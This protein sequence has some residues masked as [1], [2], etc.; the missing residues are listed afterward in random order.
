[1]IALRRT[2]AEDADWIE[3]LVGDEETEPFLSAS[4]AFDRDAIL[5]EIERSERE[6]GRFGRFVV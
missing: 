3:A 4:R 6:P 1:M 2:T 5:A